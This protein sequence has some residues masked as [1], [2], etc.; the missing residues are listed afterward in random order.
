MWTKSQLQLYPLFTSF[1]VC[2]IEKC[3]CAVLSCLIYFRSYKQLIQSALPLHFTYQN[4]L[5]LL[6]VDN[7]VTASNPNSFLLQMPYFFLYSF[8]PTNP[9]THLSYVYLNFMLCFHWLCLTTYVR[10]FLMYII[11]TLRFNNT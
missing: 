9:L 1:I 2:V 8:K 7:K 11:L 6:I 3:M 4:N 5:I 10:Q